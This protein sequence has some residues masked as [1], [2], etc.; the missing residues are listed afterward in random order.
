MDGDHQDEIHL[1]KF[2]TGSLFYMYVILLKNFTLKIMMDLKEHLL[3]NWKP[4]NYKEKG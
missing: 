1:S 2:T 4:T 3:I